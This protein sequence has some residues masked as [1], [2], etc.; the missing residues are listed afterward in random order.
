MRPAQA[1]GE[2]VPGPLCFWLVIS[3]LLWFMAASHHPSSLVSSNP[4][5]LHLH[6]IAISSLCVCLIS[7]CFPLLKIHVIAFKFHPENPGSTFYRKILNHVYDDLATSDNTYRCQGL[8]HEHLLGATFQPTTI[9]MCPVYFRD[10]KKVNTYRQR[11]ISKKESIKRWN[12]RGNTS[13]KVL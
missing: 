13:H 2:A 10:I 7:L 8:G 11:R 6:I 5:V 9:W 4:S 1:P 3:G 12:P